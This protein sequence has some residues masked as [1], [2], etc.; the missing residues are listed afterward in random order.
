VDVSVDS[1]DHY[2][3]SERT[4]LNMVR[5][6]DK[7][8]PT[9][10]RELKTLTRA[11]PTFDLCIYNAGMDPY[12]GCD[13]G[14]LS[15]ITS[16]VLAGRETMVFE[17]CQAHRIPIAFVLAGGYVGSRLTQEELVLLHRSTIEASPRDFAHS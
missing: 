10:D 2:T 17:W 6:A 14:G 3:P 7:Y 9:I 16:K 11:A 13:I 4:T 1:F 12:E 5:A 15:G 8:L